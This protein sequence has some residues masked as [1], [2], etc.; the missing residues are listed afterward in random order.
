M[1]RGFIKYIVVGLILVLGLFPSAA[2]AQAEILAEADSFYNHIT[3]TEEGS[4]RC[5]VFG[6]LTQKPETC[7]D[8]ER[9]DW[10]VLEYSAMMLVGLTL[11]PETERIAMLGLGG[12]YLPILFRLHL[13]QIALDVVEIDPE[14]LKLAEEYFLFS[15]SDKISVHVADGRRFLQGR[16]N[17]YDQVW[18][19]VFSGDYI[20]PHMTTEE[21]LVTVR[22]SLT[23]GGIVV[24]NIH[25]DQQLYD[26][27]VN[28]FRAVF[29]RVLIFEG[30]ASN[31][32]I[33]VAGSGEL[34]D[35]ADIGLDDLQTIH[36]GPVFLPEQ[37]RKFNPQPQIEDTPVLRDDFAPVNLLKRQGGSE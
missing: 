16:K 1:R 36:V 34:P 4:I 5:M 6:K 22:K 3:I 29:D 30:T 28:T 27:Q 10:P 32:A 21:F 7:I 20:P 17:L 8:I 31:N 13:P 24:Q 35:P 15:E 26:Y 37:L 33:V 11:K 14:V 19:D 12:G 9:P 23:P 25:R 18:I 2:S